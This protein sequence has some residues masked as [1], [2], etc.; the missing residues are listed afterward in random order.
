MTI[1]KIVIMIGIFGIPLGGIIASLYLIVVSNYKEG[2]T[3]LIIM[4]V[5]QII[6]LIMYRKIGIHDEIRD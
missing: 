4:I 3:S 2:F 5:V 6:F 1:T